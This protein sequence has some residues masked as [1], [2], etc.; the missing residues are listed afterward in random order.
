MAEQARVYGMADQE[1]RDPPAAQGLRGENRPGPLEGYAH[2]VTLGDGRTVTIEQDSGV[3]FAEA[4]ARAGSS[5]PQLEVAFTPES[6]SDWR[7]PALFFGLIAIA[8]GLY[9]AE[10]RRRSGEQRQRFDERAVPAR[11]DVGGGLGN[12]NVGHQS[13]V[14]LRPGREVADQR[15]VDFQ[16]TR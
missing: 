2:D 6:A 10:R 9:I 12:R 13:S 11:G 4:T 1:N 15:Q 8:G 16:P 14:G 3:A 7:R 5:D